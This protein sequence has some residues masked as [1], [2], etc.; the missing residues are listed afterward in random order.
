MKKILSLGF[1][2]IVLAGVLIGCGKETAEETTL[3]VGAT[4]L[5]H[6]ELLALIKDD[7]AAEGIEL[8]VV[9]F[10]D[11]VT[12]NLTLGEGEIDANFFQHV[13]YMNSFADEHGLELVSAGAIHVEPLGVYSASTEALSD[14]KDGATISIPNDPTNE[15]RALLL[16]HN[17]GLITLKDPEKLESTPE[18]VL[19][20]PRK[21][22]FEPIDAAQLP[23]TLEDVDAAVI[24]TNYALEA[25]LNPLEDALVLEG[26][27]SPYANIVT[28]LPEKLED[29]A[30]QALIKALQSE[31]VKAYILEH[32]EGAVVPVF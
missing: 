2:L 6:A 18:D 1:V 5:P 24:N 32:Y 28:V 30:I 22:V 12:P 11:Y 7:L 23:R 9:E 10:T 27:D 26:D 4:P 31:K 14:L 29:P 19:E 3:K 13:P 17:E 21:F 15:G 20:N 16:L 25:G 8:E